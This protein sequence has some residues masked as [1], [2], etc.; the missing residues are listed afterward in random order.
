MNDLSSRPTLTASEVGEHSF[1]AR[2]W[3]LGRVK[4]YQSVHR[5]DMAAG[6]AAHRAHGYLVMRYHRLQRLA[7]VLLLLAAVVA[8]LAMYLAW[9]GL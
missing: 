5:Q 7:H 1:C 6:R 4:G 2:S 3:W 9:R 8:V